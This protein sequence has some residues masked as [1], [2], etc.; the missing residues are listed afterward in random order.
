[1]S[2]PELVVGTQN[3]DKGTE[4]FARLAHLPLEL[5]G[6]WEWSDAEPVE[7]TG[8][9]L[10][11]NALLKAEAAAIHTG[12]WAIADDTGL[13]VDAL[14]GA[15]GV[16]SA[17][18]AGPNATY[19]DNRQKLLNDLIDVSG[20][21][22]GAR[23]TTVIAL[24]RPGM[25][26]ETMTGSVEG[27]ITTS[28]QGEGGFGYD[29][30]FCAAGNALTFAQMTVEEKNRIAHRGLALEALVRRLEDLLV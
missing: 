28:E 30:I 10:K 23:F 29:P 13:E 26:P 14:C 25:P 9:T 8:E 6:M 15:P 19:S 1:M 24:V 3:R 5:R 11:D 4:I 20:P 7:E 2:A 17:R 27:T 16:Y 22:R 12:M 21:G 18:F